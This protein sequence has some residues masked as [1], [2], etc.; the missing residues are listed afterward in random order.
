MIYFTRI[1]IPVF[2]IKVGEMKKFIKKSPPFQI[3]EKKGKQEGEKLFN[4]V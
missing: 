3:V 1:F 4:F 2:D